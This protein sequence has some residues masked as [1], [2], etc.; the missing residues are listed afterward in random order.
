MKFEERLAEIGRFLERELRQ[1]FP[2]WT[3]SRLGSQNWAATLPGQD[4]IY[5]RSG[6]EL[7]EALRSRI[8]QR[9]GDP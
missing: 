1:E 7:R 5:A 4:T 8:R 3:I 6:G 2:G 9:R